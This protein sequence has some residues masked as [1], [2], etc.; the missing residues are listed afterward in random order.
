MREQSKA[1]IAR[2]D[3]DL[4]HFKLEAYTARLA[5]KDATEKVTKES[6]KAQEALKAMRDSHLKAESEWVARIEV[7]Q[8][9]LKA[10]EAAQVK[11]VEAKAVVARKR[12]SLPVVDL[13]ERNRLA[14]FCLLHVFCAI[15]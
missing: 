2:Y 9:Q 1:E 8:A 14:D 3:A 11:E 15:R 5:E 6:V 12:V 4:K 13:R 7:L 10:L